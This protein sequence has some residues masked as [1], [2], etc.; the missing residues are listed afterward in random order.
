NCT[1]SPRVFNGIIHYKTSCMSNRVAANVTVTAP[2][3][4]NAVAATSFV[5]NGDSVQLH[6]TSSNVNYRYSWTPTSELSDSTGSNVFAYPSSISTYF[7]HAHD[8]ITNCNTIDSVTVNA[9]AP[10]AIEATTNR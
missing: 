2:P 1:G 10:P 9:F 6:A 4:I 5:C 3:S 8:S 7:L